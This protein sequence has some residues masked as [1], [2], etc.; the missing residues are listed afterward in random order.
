MSMGFTQLQ[1]KEVICL[2]DGRRLGFVS[3]V[4]IELPSGEVKA[5]VVPCPVR[6]PGALGR[7]EDYRIPW[8]CI[9]RLGPDIVL[10]DTKPDDCRYPR[11]PRK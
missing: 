5:I 8:K 3:D 9:Q 7:R 11:P 10:V 1:C 2:A 4:L 6:F